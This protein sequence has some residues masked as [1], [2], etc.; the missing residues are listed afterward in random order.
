MAKGHRSRYKKERNENRESRPRASHMYARISD[1]K[2]RIVLN[3]IKGKN[4]ATAL[5]ILTYSPRYAAA[6]IKKVLQS[7]IANAE[8]NLGMDAGDLYVEEAVANRGP[9]MKRIQPRARG[10]AYRIQKRSSHI[11]IILNER[12]EVR[13]GAKGTSSRA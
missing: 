10:S 4:V 6:L 11:S 8:Y 9:I 13:D 12:Q 3:Q 1:T 2:A 5:G 7:A